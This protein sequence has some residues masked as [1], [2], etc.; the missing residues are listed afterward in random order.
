MQVPTLPPIEGL[1]P[2]PSVSTVAVLPQQNTQTNDK[3]STVN[4]DAL[5][6]ELQSYKQQNNCTYF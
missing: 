1:M 3:E 4:F 5:L 2:S 6:A